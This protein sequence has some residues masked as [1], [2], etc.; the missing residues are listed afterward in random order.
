MRGL[1]TAGQEAVFVVRIMATGA[2]LGLNPRLVA[3]QLCS[4]WQVT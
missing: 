2:S 4:L 1:L 3:C